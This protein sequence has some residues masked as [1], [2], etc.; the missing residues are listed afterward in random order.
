MLTRNAHS[1]DK[2]FVSNGMNPNQNAYLNLD[3]AAVTRVVGGV[4]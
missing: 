4:R 1:T 2:P 3:A